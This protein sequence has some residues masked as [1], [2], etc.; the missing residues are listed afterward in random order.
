QSSV[1]RDSADNLMY[2]PT[3]HNIW[4]DL[5][6]RFH[7]SNSRRSYQIKK[8][9]LWDKLRDYS[10]TSSMLAKAAEAPM[11]RAQVKEKPVTHLK[12][13]DT[14]YKTVRR[15]FNDYNFV[16]NGQISTSGYKYQE[17]KPSQ[18]E[19]EKEDRVL[20][21]CKTKN[22]KNAQHK[23]VLVASLHTKF[24]LVCKLVKCWL[25]GVLAAA[26]RRSGLQ[27]GSLQSKSSSG[28]FPIAEEGET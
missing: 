22:N 14:K 12:P 1:A 7:E 23:A 6:D 25:L 4:A 28:S 18:S 26:G 9:E 2:M 15:L 10:L 16:S 11:K 5:H 8:E 24:Q 21:K 19:N 20:C 27:R 3:A 17:Q 13:K